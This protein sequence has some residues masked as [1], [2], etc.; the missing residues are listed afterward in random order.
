MNLYAL[1]T[2]SIWNDEGNSLSVITFMEVDNVYPEVLVIS[3]KIVSILSVLLS[4]KSYLLTT[5]FHY[6]LPTYFISSLISNKK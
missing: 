6:F 2:N 1:L 5:P 3:T 4:G